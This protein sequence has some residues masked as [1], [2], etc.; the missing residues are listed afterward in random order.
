MVRW[1]VPRVFFC[2]DKKKKA[3]ESNKGIFENF[4][5]Q[6]AISREK[7]VRSRQI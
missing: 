6:F 2:D 7:K 3:D 5:K 1:W 4:F